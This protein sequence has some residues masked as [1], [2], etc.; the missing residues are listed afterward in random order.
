MS[1][2]TSKNKD[3]KGRE[4]TS[5]SLDEE[6]A[7]AP[8]DKNPKSPP[9]PETRKK[10]RLSRLTKPGKKKEQPGQYSYDPKIADKTVHPNKIPKDERFFQFARTITAFVAA[11]IS[12]RYS[13]RSG[14]LTVS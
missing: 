1:S 14:D 10:A 2:S 11:S 13:I 8:A 6:V 3:S 9:P 4:N 7:T 12:D 5:S